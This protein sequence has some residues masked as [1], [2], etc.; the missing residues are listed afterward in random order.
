MATGP[1]AA[2]LRARRHPVALCTGATGSRAF[3]VAD[4]PVIVAPISLRSRTVAGGPWHTDF[5]QTNAHS[6]QLTRDTQAL[7]AARPRPT[8]PANP[9]RHAAPST[10][11]GRS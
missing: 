5:T 2:K 9:H 4:A 6:S 11:F 7:P 1:R 3:A 8:P 10:R